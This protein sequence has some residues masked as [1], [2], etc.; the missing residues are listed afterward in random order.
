MNDWFQCSRQ[1][2]VPAWE[3]A[4]TNSVCLVTV[5]NFFLYPAINGVCVVSKH[6]IPTD[7]VESATITQIIKTRPRYEAIL[8]SGTGV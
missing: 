7:D 8:A 1:V 4:R 6:R 5:R 2:P 3:S